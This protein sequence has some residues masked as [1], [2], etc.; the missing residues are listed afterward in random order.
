MNLSSTKTYFIALLGL[1]RQ[2]QIMKLS[3]SLS[4]YAAFALSPILIVLAALMSLFYRE[5]ALHELLSQ[6]I[7]TY[8]DP[9]TTEALLLFS[10]KAAEF[11]F[12]WGLPLL[13]LLTILYASTFA[14][15]E[16]ADSLN[17]IW[18]VPSQ[19]QSW[20]R[21]ILRSKVFALIL[22]PLLGL[23]L[24]SLL[25]LD[26]FIA[27][28]FSWFPKQFESMM[29]L[30]TKGTHIAV[31]FVVLGGL[32]ALLYKK[33]PDRFVSWP[34][35]WAP[36]LITA[37]LF[38]V[39]QRLVS[40]YLANNAMV[41]YYGASSSLMVILIWVYINAHIFYFGAMMVRA[42]QLIQKRK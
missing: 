33:L 13:A 41:S 12:G 36:S 9:R 38:V 28:T 40:W 27:W 39:S 4:F 2:H 8:M 17:Q 1:L 16:L 24:L 3:A 18:E 32:L 42:N 35:T 14:F 5:E 21:Y 23:L 25:L 26:T 29:W 30:L 20:A 15:Q 7:G 22:L 19:D 10:E 31:S 34:C 11:E 37:L 6:A